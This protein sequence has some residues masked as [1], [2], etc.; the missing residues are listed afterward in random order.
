MLKVLLEHASFNESLSANKQCKFA[1][2]ILCQ[3]PK[4]IHADAKVG[5]G[6]LYG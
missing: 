5:S 1:L 4:L 6:F 3:L 2:L